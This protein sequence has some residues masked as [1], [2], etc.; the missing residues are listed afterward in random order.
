MARKR[1]FPLSLLAIYL[2]YS[3]LAGHLLAA[4]IKSAL[5]S[6]KMAALWTASIT[7]GGQSEAERMSIDFRNTSNC[8][9]LK[10]ASLNTPLPVRVHGGTR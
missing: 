6:S 1:C 4:I 10:P 3:V 2:F 9:A 8:V 5:L 7:L